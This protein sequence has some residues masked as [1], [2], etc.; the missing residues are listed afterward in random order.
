MLRDDRFFF[1]IGI[2]FCKNYNVEDEICE[3]IQMLQIS[4]YVHQMWNFFIQ[5]D[6]KIFFKCFLRILGDDRIFVQI[7]IIFFENCDFEDE[8]YEFFQTQNFWIFP[9]DVKLLSRTVFNFFVYVPQHCMT[10]TG[11]RA[12]FGRV[13]TKIKILRMKFVNFFK[14]TDFLIFSTW[15][16]T[17]FLQCRFF[18][19]QMFVDFLFW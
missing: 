10:V 11:F 16:E 3:F 6:N 4:R 2:I 1:W 15:C 7:W 13:I 18:F 9:P 8:I 17:L 5:S 12:K 19:L 14:F